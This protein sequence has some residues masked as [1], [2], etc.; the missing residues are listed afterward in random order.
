MGIF[1][2]LTVYPERIPEDRWEEVYE[3]TLHI[4]DRSDFLDRVFMERNGHRYVAARKTAERDFPEDGPGICVCGTMTSGFDMEEFYLFRQKPRRRGADKPDNGADI[5]FA[6]W[7]PEDPDIPVP[8]GAQELWGNKTQGRPG[9]IP[10]LAIACLFADRFPEAVK[11]GGDITAGQCRAA[12]HLANQ[13][14]EHPIQTPV[15]CRAEAL[16]QRLRRLNIPVT[17]QLSAFFQLLLEKLTPETGEVLMR[18]FPEGALYQYFM[19]RM[20]KEAAGTARFE[21]LLRDYLLLRLAPSDLLRMLVQDPAGPQLPL[22]KVLSLLFHC[23]VHVPMENK[24]CVN[25]LGLDAAVEGD[26]ESPHEIEALM[27]RAFFAMLAG[28]NRNLPVYLPLDTIRAACRQACPNTDTDALIDQLLAKPAED[29]RQE[30][31]YGSGDTALMNRLRKTAKERWDQISAYD[32]T[33]PADLRRWH[34]GLTI[35]PHLENSLLEMMKQIRAFSVEREYQEFLGLEQA[36]REAYFIC[37]NRYILIYE[38]VW[39]YMFARM[40]DNQYIYRFFL[41]FC[42]D[43]SH[44]KIH[45]ILS[46]LLANPPLIDM[47][48]ER[49]TEEAAEA[50]N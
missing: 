35:E 28:R 3:E 22:E 8:A 7:Y 1:L 48:W 44:K 33:E 16:A 19:Q 23:Q 45:D 40:M 42:V 14:L 26:E 25:P 11:I 39:E 36:E 9:H 46:A 31:V 49:S 43:C 32:L 10:L 6:D 30:Q 41:L 12:V 24:N 4:V 5:L 18:L 21:E 34:P 29:K 17:K 37:R 50:G 15:T 47:L 38:S 27:G 13:S 2:N 20:T